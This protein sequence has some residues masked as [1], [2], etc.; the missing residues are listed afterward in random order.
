MH[1]NSAISNLIA[2]SSL[3]QIASVIETGGDQ[4]MWTLD[5]S[6]AKLWRKRLISEKTAR[7]LARNPSLLS[8]LSKHISRA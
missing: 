1:V 6:L 2:T 3:N 8:K 5:G 4:G 7:S